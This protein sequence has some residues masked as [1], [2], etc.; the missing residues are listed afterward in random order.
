MDPISINKIIDIT[1]GKLLSKKST[2]NITSISIDSRKIARGSLFIPICGTKMDGHD[3]IEQAFSAG[4][5]AAL[6]QKVDGLP[7]GKILIKVDNTLDAL[8]KIA[9]DYRRNFTIP[10]I[11]ITGSVGKTSTKEMIASVL[12]VKFCVA[13]TKGN[14]NGQIGLPLS[15]FEI[16]QKHQVAVIEMGISEFGEMSK[17]SKIAFPTRAV[18]T[19]IGISHIANLKSQEYICQE[20][21]HILDEFE[22]Q[23]VKKESGQ[24]IFLNADDPVLMH[25]A[26]NISCPKICFGF[27]ENAEFRASNIFF[28]K[29]FTRF[30]LIHKSIEKNIE[31]PVLGKHNVY[32][33]LAAIAVGFNFGLSLEEI[34]S[35]LSNYCGVG[36][37]Q[38]IHRTN[39]LT[40]I[41]DSYNASPDSMRS[42]VELLEQFKGN[43][44]KIA[45]LGDM[46]ELGEHAQEE[47]YKLGKFLSKKI[48]ILLTVGNL[49]KYIAKGAQDHD[50]RIEVHSHSTK[51]ETIT[52]LKTHTLKA[53]IILVK[54][55]RGMHLD[56]VITALLA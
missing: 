36:M 14:F 9:A 21:L 41:D 22:N 48:N 25:F 7:S 10:V 47:H 50:S 13:K 18:I 27:G 33:A 42:A 19:N 11:G 56:K 31:I 20:K 30:S 52:W 53:D 1:G 51:Q 24:T 28:Y 46:L 44:R 3:F 2:A 49:A 34:Q 45:V 23:V 38:Q 8:Q 39:G 43:A 54:G 5:V 12:S 35:G 15:I 40:L 4:A 29:N 16:E 17:L 37:R 55:S 32:N 26:K 6:T